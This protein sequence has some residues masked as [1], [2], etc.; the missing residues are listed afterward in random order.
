MAR[1]SGVAI[2]AV[3]AGLALSGCA[4]R[5]LSVAGS[6][7]AAGQIQA[8]PAGT[9]VELAEG[10]YRL[11]DVRV[12]AGVS[13]RGAGYGKTILDATGCE[14]GLVLTGGKAVTFSDFTIRGASGAG[15]VIRGASKQSVERVAV[16]DCAAGVIVLSSSGCSL[17]NLVVG[18][19]QAGVSFVDSSDS[20]LVSATLVGVQGTG[21]T[22]GGCRGVTV[23]NTLVDGAAMGISLGEGNRGLVID[24]NMYNANYVG[25]MPG[26]TTRK[27]VQTWHHLT[28][29]DRHSQTIGVEFAN[30]AA[31]DYRVVSPLPWSPNR[32]T[33]G[34][35]GALV[36]NGVKAPPLDMNGQKRSERPDVG[37]FESSL[38]PPRQADGT[39]TVTGGAGVTSAGLFTKDGQNVRYLF[40]SLP[41]VKGTYAYWLPTRDWQG[42]PIAA[43]EYELRWLES[44]LKLEYLMAAGNGTLETSKRLPASTAIRNSLHPHQAAF[45]GADNVVLAQSG[46]ENALYLRCFTDDLSRIPWSTDGG[47]Q[48]FGVAVDGNVAHALRKPCS[49]IRIDVRTGKG[50]PF[51]SGS[52][53]KSYDEAIPAPGGM[54]M[55]GGA[56]FISEPAANRIH[57]LTG[58]ELELTASFDAP[59]P[60]QLAGD[61][62][63]GVLW[64]LGGG[65]V[66]AF[67]AMG[68]ELTVSVPVEQPKAIAANHGRLAVYSAKTNQVTL[69]DAAD[70]GNLKPIRVV[71]TGGEGY[72]KIIGE[73]FW[74]PTALALGGKGQLLV[75]DAPRTILFDG[76]GK[77]KRQIMAMWGQLISY[78]QFAGDDRMHFFSMGSTHD[79]V[80]DAKKRTWELG[81]HW[82]YTMPHDPGY[83]HVA[84]YYALGGKTFCLYRGQATADMLACLY[85]ARMDLDTGI[86]R[87]LLRFGY[88]SE[89]FYRQQADAEGIVAADAPK[90]YLTDGQGQ[91]VRLNYRERGFQNIDYDADGRLVVPWREGMQVVP[92]TG[93]DEQGVPQYDFTKM[94]AIK[95]TVEGKTT[96]LSPYDFKTEDN[97]SIAEDLSTF[98]DGSFS[99]VMSL[100]KSGAGSDLCGEHASATD[101]AGFNA[102][103]EMRWFYPLNPFGLKMG[104]WGITS[105]GGITFAG[106]GAQAEWEAM[107]RDGLGAGLLGPPADFGWSGM[108][109]DNHRQTHAF[110]GNDGKPYMVVGDY[111]AQAYH[112]MAIKGLDGLV[113]RTQPVTIDATLAGTLAQAP[114]QLPPHFPQPL[115]PKVVVKRIDKDLPMDGDLAKWRTLGIT[116]I[117]A[118]ADLSKKNDPRDNSAVI[119][120]AWNAASDKLFVQVLKFDDVITFHHKQLWQHFLQDGFEMNINTF[121]SGWKFNLTR[122]E[123]KDMVIRDRLEPDR[124]GNKRPLAVLSDDMV[125][126][127]ITILDSAKDVEE[128]KLLEAPRG[129]DMSGCKVM[130]IE[131]TLTKAAIDDMHKTGNQMEFGSGQRFHFGFSINDSDVPGDTVMAN[132][133]IWPAMYLTFARTEQLAEATLE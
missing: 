103:G 78:G 62:K 128:R 50:V 35:M 17:S 11:G 55:L 99:A 90:E 19:A 42:R 23:F 46:F 36:F 97:V 95:A 65:R 34:L 22:I 113:R 58:E 85:V 68:K 69:F 40:Q 102:A 98:E 51:A 130:V 20:H 59:S 18:N 39:F 45:D 2:V 84:A 81:T 5:A 114:A 96:F 91:A 10:V 129:L 8:A 111:I 86:A 64:A 16:R 7:D 53:E 43:G 28:G 3:A 80:L 26:Q 92:V 89:G 83:A 56:M 115:P 125:P 71:G 33:T 4:E 124:L 131:F 112:W 37:A 60:T 47:G 94:Q 9:V 118:A 29:F 120:M 82:T 32:A 30:A 67:D 88:D 127:K 63:T 87:V 70:Y 49:L 48:T 38:T 14:N 12:P 109:L 72:G 117:V 44:D 79:I 57:M 73:R 132:T 52:Y 66:V 122:M 107:D 101:M 61:G 21:V 76:N 106:R 15:L 13:I 133:I 126:R 121:Y 119:R 108:W 93:L 24:H 110:T 74:S 25:R 104:F 75:I 105:I 100:Y 54:T 77:L 1:F 6:G 123:G 116:P 31:G 27:H 41:L